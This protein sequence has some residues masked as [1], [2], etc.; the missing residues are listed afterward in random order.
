MDEVLV[1]AVRHRANYACEYCHLPEALHPGPYEIEHVIAKKHGGPTVLSNL[2]Y[3]CLHC[4]RHKG[5]DLAGIDRA[6]SRTRLV[7]LFNPR[8]HLWRRH[9]RWED[10][11]LIGRTAIGRVTIQLLQMNDPVRTILRV[12][13]LG[14]GLF[15]G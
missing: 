3:S 7:R 5:S 8:R 12:E 15:I 2:A 11:R 10:A 1:R 9:F 6:T 13:L 4:N 14:E